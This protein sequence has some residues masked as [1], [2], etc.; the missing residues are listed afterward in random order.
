MP[1]QEAISLMEERAKRFSYF[2]E[3]IRALPAPGTDA[4]IKNEIN[5]LTKRMNTLS[6]ETRSTREIL[7]DL[8]K[9]F[10]FYANYKYA[11]EKTI[12][13]ITLVTSHSQRKEKEES[14]LETLEKLSPEREEKLK[15]FIE[16]GD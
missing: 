8:Q 12:T 5:Y 2:S 11:L 6:K 16:E 13:P 7:N 15:K 3:F 10:T 1:T 4:E 9:Q 14:L